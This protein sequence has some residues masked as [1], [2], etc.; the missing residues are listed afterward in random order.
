MLANVNLNITQIDDIKRT[1]V[2]LVLYTE[3]FMSGGNG[4][5]GHV[6]GEDELILIV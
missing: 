3:M 5:H 6:S 1:D 4:E 2:P